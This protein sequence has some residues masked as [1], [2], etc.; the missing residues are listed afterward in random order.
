M[1]IRWS[2]AIVVAIML[3]SVAAGCGGDSETTAVTKEQFVKEANSICL[4]GEAKRGQMLNEL[5]SQFGGGKVPQAQR[6]QLVL[7][8]LPT[9]EETATNLGEL[10]PP[11]GDEKEVEAIVEAMEEAVDRVKAD[12]NTALVGTIPFDKANKLANGYGLDRCDV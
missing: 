1:N 3:A 2:W 12:P 11:A 5:S 4:K 8:V 6:E 9:Y 7:K 10:D